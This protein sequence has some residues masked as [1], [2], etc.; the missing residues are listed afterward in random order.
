[1]NSSTMNSIPSGYF[2]HCS[3]C[4]SYNDSSAHWVHWAVS[5]IFSFVSTLG[6]VL[7]LALL[8][9]FILGRKQLSL[10]PFYIVA[11][12]LLFANFI[13][14]VTQL[15]VVVPTPLLGPESSYVL[16]VPYKALLAAELM[17]QIAFYHFIALQALL[18]AM[19]FFVTYRW[20][21]TRWLAS[22][23]NW[24]CAGVWMWCAGLLYYIHSGCEEEFDSATYQF[25]SQ[26][27][28]SSWIRVGLPMWHAVLIAAAGGLCAVGLLRV[29]RRK[30]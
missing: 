8:G 23:G 9:I 22:W 26:C 21:R 28:D 2:Q 15:G 17:S 20:S 11:M 30:R 18:Q 5:V 1:M 13:S 16:S 6:I 12:H 7:E 25:H 19:G 10:Q 24:I 27:K 4:N 29:N 3:N 14:L